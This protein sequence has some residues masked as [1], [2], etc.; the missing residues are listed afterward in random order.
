MF[1][2]VKYTGGQFGVKSYV[3]KVTNIDSKGNI[4]RKFL[5][6]RKSFYLSETVCELEI[7]AALLKIGD[8]LTTKLLWGRAKLG[9][10]SKDGKDMK[11]KET[12][13]R[14]DAEPKEA[15]SLMDSARKL[16]Y[17]ELRKA[18]TQ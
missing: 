10:Y 13:Y 16:S 18:F 5:P 12:Y 9:N 2:P 6:L 15:K 17:R 1:I 11:I 8:Y 7:D 4:V 14:I 3:A